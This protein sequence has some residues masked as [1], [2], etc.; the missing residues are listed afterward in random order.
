MENGKIRNEAEISAY[1]G[2]GFSRNDGFQAMARGSAI[3][4]FLFSIFH[5]PF[6]SLR[7]SLTTQQRFGAYFTGFGIGCVL[8]G[9]YLSARGLP[10]SPE[11]PAPGVIRREVPGALAQWMI[12][13]APVDGDFIL[14]HDDNRTTGGADAATGR[15]TRALVVSGLDPGAFIRV[16][17][18]SFNKDPDKVVDWKY[19]F[20][21]HA[22]A[23]LQPG[24]D[25][26][27]LADAMNPFGWH[28]VGDKD[29][30]GWA[31]ILLNG[32]DVKTLPQALAQLRAWPQ[33]VAAAEPDYLPAP[34]LI[35]GAPGP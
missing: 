2:A 5:L 25:T 1:Q 14:S 24:V 28:F 11:P 6:Y 34:S 23:Q 13:G 26:R 32:H 7:M 10:H 31:T 19:M 27:T 16:E 22:R 20:A 30:D 15:F 33:W 17:E 35:H 4:I 9:I 21:D 3:N 8:V 18:D 12:T 29:K